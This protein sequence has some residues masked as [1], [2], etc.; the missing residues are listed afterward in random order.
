MHI[1]FPI[2]ALAALIPLLVGFLWYNPRVFGK[3]WMKITGMTEEKAK[4]TNMLVV[5]GLTYL[6]GFLA[7]MSLVPMTLHVF[8]VGG[9]MDGLTDTPG[10][11]EIKSHAEVLI[12]L[13]AD[14]FRS[15]GHGTL[16]G[17]LAGV[18]MA[19]PVIAVNAMFEGHRFKYIAINAGFWIVCLILMGGVIC[20]F[21]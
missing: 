8:S 10:D 15:F 12:K 17:G 5:F 7:A 4:N 18:F 6:L 13:N 9:L 14:R 11:L 3:A 1:N 19:L 21:F 2:I 20:R 16:H